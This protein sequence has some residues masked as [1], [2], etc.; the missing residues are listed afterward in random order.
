MI[1]TYGYQCQILVPAILSSASLVENSPLLMLSYLNDNQNEGH[2]WILDGGGGGTTDTYTEI[3]SFDYNKDLVNF[4]TDETHSSL[5][6]YYIN[7]GWGKDNG[8]Y[9]NLVPKGYN[10]NKLFLAYKIK[11]NI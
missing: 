7:W 5:Q 9:T 8:Y 3:W 2:A 11:P 1:V 6:Y 4:H 10:S